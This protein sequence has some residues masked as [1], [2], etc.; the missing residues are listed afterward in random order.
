MK[1]E[2]KQPLELSYL[3][4]F[5]EGITMDENNQ[6]ILDENLIKEGWKIGMGFQERSNEKIVSDEIRRLK[7]LRYEVKGLMVKEMEYI[8]C[9]IYREKNN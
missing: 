7:E 5:N 2:M 8:R 6:F 3:A 1:E 4:Y 9:L